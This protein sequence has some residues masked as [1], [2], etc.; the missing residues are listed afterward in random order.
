MIARESDIAFIHL[1]LVLL[2][3][4]AVQEVGIP[5]HAESTLV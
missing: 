1:A 4:A 5:L 2:S 3:D